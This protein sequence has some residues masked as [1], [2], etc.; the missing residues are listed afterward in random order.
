MRHSSPCFRRLP[1]SL[2]GLNV[3]GASSA[4]IVRK[5]VCHVALDMDADVTMV[6]RALQKVQ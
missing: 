1:T 2:Q 6:V 5:F 3:R 4:A